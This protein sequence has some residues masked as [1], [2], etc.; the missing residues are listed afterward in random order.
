MFGP[1]P[2]LSKS[3]HCRLTLP[4]DASFFPLTNVPNLATRLVRTTS[5][6]YHKEEGRGVK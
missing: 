3:P 5:L 2:N 6:D 4:L 1:C